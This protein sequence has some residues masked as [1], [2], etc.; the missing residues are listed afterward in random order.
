[1]AVGNQHSDFN[2]C[3]FLKTE[4]RPLVAQRYLFIIKKKDKPK[5]LCTLNLSF[6]Y[7]P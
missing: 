2:D 4:S 6:F 7:H 3:R 5:V 1:M